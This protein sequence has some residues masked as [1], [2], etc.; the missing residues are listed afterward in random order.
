MKQFP[1]RTLYKK[2]HKPSFSYSTIEQQ[3]NT[4]PTKGNF[5]LV[6]RTSGRLTYKQIESGRRSVPRILRKSGFVTIRPFTYVSLTKKPLA[7]RMGKGKGS[8]YLWIAPIRAG[9]ILYEIRYKDP[10]TASLALSRVARKMPFRTKVVPL[11]Y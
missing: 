5:A 8:H 11:V 9:Q 7:T 4:G 3:R 2:Y 10:L 1:K 6:S